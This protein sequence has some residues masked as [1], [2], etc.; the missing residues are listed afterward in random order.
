M[1]KIFRIPELS[2]NTRCLTRWYNEF[3]LGM[4]NVFR[5]P[6]LSTL[7][8]CLAK[9]RLYLYGL[10]ACYSVDAAQGDVCRYFAKFSVYERPKV[11]PII[12]M[13]IVKLNSLKGDF[14]KGFPQDKL[15]FFH[16]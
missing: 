6:Q 5:I 9:C 7:T 16:A 12:V 10:A 15:S 11:N 4:L 14:L 8:R 13:L 1:L 2:M 3:S